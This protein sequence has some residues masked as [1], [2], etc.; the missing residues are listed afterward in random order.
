[1]AITESDWIPS[2]VELARVGCRTIISIA[3]LKLIVVSQLHD[4]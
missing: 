1:M 4:N 3:K 2:G